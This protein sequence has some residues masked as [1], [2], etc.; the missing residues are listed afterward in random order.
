MRARC[1]RGV[2]LIVVLAMLLPAGMA[3]ASEPRI[4]RPVAWLL[5][6]AV[7]VP[8]VLVAARDRSDARGTLEAIAILYALLLAGAVGIGTRMR[9]HTSR[10]TPPPG[11]GR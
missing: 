10:R 7:A 1:T 5:P 6:I 3:V 9:D 11:P 2:V 8:L 4:P